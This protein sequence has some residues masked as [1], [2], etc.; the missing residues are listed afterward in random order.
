VYNV[1]VIRKEVTAVKNSKKED[2]M[3][4]KEIDRLIDWLK[5]KGHTAEEATQCIKY[6]ANNK[7]STDKSA[8]N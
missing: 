8:D 7:T 1:Y 5:S 2:A 6:I 4:V 3:T